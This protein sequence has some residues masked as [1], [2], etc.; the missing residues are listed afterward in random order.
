[1]SAPDNAELLAVAVAAARAAAPELVERF[2]RGAVNVT[3]KSTDTDLVSDAD[4]AAERTIRALLERER[5]DDAIMGEEGDDTPGTTGLRWVV[6]PL[7]GT[8][9]YL[10]GHPQWCVSVAC[11]GRAGVVLDPIR[12]ELFAV[13]VG[14]APTLN[15]APLPPASTVE[16]LGSALVATGFG[17]AADVRAAQ[18]A[19]VARVLPAVRDIRRAGS[20]ALDLAWIAAGRLDA[21]YEHGVKPWDIAAGVLLCESA[22]LHVEPLAGGDGLPQGILAAPAGLAD[23]L[24]TLIGS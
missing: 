21:Y 14:Q 1:M 12:D 3:S 6:D 23:E 7:D 11:E 8:I 13:A 16:E 19:I 2:A 24:L 4:L 5:P 22:G 9:D 17:Y 20:A 10:Y 15:G 18:A